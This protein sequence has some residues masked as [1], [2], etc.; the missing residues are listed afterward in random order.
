MEGC[1]PAAEAV[2][3]SLDVNISQQFSWPVRYSVSAYIIHCPASVCDRYVS[4]S[5]SLFASM[6]SLKVPLCHDLGDFLPLKPSHGL[7]H[8]PHEGHCAGN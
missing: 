6:R 2:C 3:A 1:V 4:V 5:V 7:K 8:L